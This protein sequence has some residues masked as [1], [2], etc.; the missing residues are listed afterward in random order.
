MI[1][2]SVTR[3][4]GGGGGEGGR[5][6]LGGGGGEGGGGGCGE[7]GEGGGGG[8]GK[9]GGEGGLRG[10]ATEGEVR[11]QACAR[12]ECVRGEYTLWKAR[13]CARGQMRGSA[14]GAGTVTRRSR[15]CHVAATRRSKRACHV[16]V[17]R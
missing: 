14:E 16:I 4:M 6:L 1:P 8:L 10:A 9:G 3:W 12:C 13:R 5:A 2:I 7:G 11:T 15:G 17:T